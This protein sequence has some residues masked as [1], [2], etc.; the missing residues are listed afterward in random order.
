MATSDEL[1]RLSE[2][3]KAVLTAIASELA[4]SD[5]AFVRRMTGAP[6]PERVDPEPVAAR[7]VLLVALTLWGVASMPDVWQ[8][9]LGVVLTLGVPAILWGCAARSTR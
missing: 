5:P 4:A 1:G 6:A 7:G 2:R 9:V 8:S 3:E